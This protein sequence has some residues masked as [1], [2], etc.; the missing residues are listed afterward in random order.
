[1]AVLR[2]LY[3]QVFLL[4]LVTCCAS[5]AEAK[6]ILVLVDGNND[7][8]AGSMNRVKRFAR[9]EKHMTVMNVVWSNFK[10]N[11]SSGAALD[12]QG[13]QRFVASGK[14]YL[15]NLPAGTNIYMIGHSWGGDSALRLVDAYQGS[16][17]NFR[18]LAL[19]DPVGTAGQRSVMVNT[20]YVPSKVEYFYNR[21]QTNQP[22]PV[23]FLANGKFLCYAQTCDQDE[24]STHKNA[25]GSSVRVSCEAY[26]VTCPGYDPTPKCKVVWRG[27]KSYLKCEPGS[28]GTKMKRAGH[29][30]L[31]T[32]GYVEE[33]LKRII[34]QL[35]RNPPK[36][37][38][39]PNMYLKN[40]CKDSISVAIRYLDYYTNEWTSKC[41]Y[42]LESGQGFYVASGGARLETT[43]TVWY[44]YAESESATWS[45]NDSDSITRTCGG[46]SLPM[47][48][49]DYV[50][51]DGDLYARFTCDRRRLRAHSDKSSTDLPLEEL[52]FKH[53]HKETIDPV[54]TA[55]ETGEEDPCEEDAPLWGTKQEEVPIKVM[56]HLEDDNHGHGPS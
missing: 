41:W 7:C 5:Q 34:D 3:Q 21:Y 33:S 24:Q 8:C 10:E 30:G 16:N 14:E 12:D 47:K 29:S 55:S 32:D 46:E 38:K 25:D 42:N 51:S 9:D 48:R 56:T 6:D 40:D 17:V 26:E 28:N 49:K 22:F 4:L 23:D 37:P 52:Y 11:W 18:L 1:M 31:A 20:N 35:I 19:I 13:K 27:L 54:C 15:E 53:D 2:L 39:R 50:D 45:G 44:T 36:P 43:N